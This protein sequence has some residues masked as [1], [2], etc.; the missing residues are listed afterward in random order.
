MSRFNLAA[1]QAIGTRPVERAYRLGGI[2]IPI[3]SPEPCY[4]LVQLGRGQPV[5]CQC[6]RCAAR[7][8]S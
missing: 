1:L 4:R 2:A 8:A 7:S 5:T 3:I 6:S